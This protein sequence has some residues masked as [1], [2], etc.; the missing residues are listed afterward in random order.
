M[1]D[2]TNKKRD[3]S[4]LNQIQFQVTQKKGT[5]RPYTGEYNNV[6]D[7]GKYN[8]IVCNE[9]LFN[10]VNKFDSGCGW[11]AFSKPVNDKVIEEISDTSHG[12][13]RTETNCNNCGAHLGHVFND[14]PKINGG[15][16]YCINSASLNFTKEKK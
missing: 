15:L 6:Y 10:S 12:M 2:K 14:G 5:E 8:C 4:H 16:R 13:V 1:Q 9:L 11:P 3:L 7:E